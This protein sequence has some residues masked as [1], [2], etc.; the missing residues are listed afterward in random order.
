MIVLN[1]VVVNVKWDV[2]HEV[3]DM[4][5]G[6]GSVNS[7][8]QW[9]GGLVFWCI[10][11]MQQALKIMIHMCAYSVGHTLRV[12]CPM[13]KRTGKREKASFGSSHTQMFNSG[14]F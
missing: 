6:R 9:S 14:Y 5:P 4:R 2:K 3:L 8:G 10:H 13:R 1:R 7:S 12:C 11:T